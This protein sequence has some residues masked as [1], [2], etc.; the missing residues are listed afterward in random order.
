LEPEKFLV[1]ND[2]YRF[3]SKLG[4]LIL[5]GQTGTNVNDIT[6]IVVL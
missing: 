3:F 5:T 4:D 2:S 1:D 6:V